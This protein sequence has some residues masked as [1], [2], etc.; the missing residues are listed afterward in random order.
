[1]ADSA[2]DPK[3]ED[4]L[5]SVRRLVSGEIP[6]KSRAPLPKGPG[7]LVL[8]DADRVKK[9]PPSRNAARSLEQRIAELEA[10][11][12]SGGEEFEP[13]GSEDQTQNIPDRIIYTRP[14]TSEEQAEARRSTLRL[15]EI[16]LIETGPADEED[17]DSE[18]ASAIAF[19]HGENTLKTAEVAEEET[20]EPETGAAAVETSEEAEAAPMAADVP[21]LPPKRADVTAFTN[22]DDVVERIE[23]RIDRGD[24]PATDAPIAA[25]SQ[26]DAA[27]TEADKQ[28]NMLRE[29]VVVPTES[30]DEEFDEALTE[31][32]EASVTTAVFEELSSGHSAFEA[33]ETEVAPEDSVEHAPADATEAQGENDEA[34]AADTETETAPAAPLPQEEELR[35]LVASLMREELQGELG[36][37]ITRNVRKLVR[38]EIKRALDARD[39]V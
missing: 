17:A 24:E 8:T 31:A 10:A 12:D 38:R 30:E 9:D 6:R 14:P 1:M 26:P 18:A 29:D 16:A 15:S 27:D 33:E 23:A 36:E 13:D 22:P 21:T 35:K 25:R 3:V 37:R 11:V 7:A 39:L 28:E 34:P 4:V 2:S 32:V 20:K 5:S 19:R